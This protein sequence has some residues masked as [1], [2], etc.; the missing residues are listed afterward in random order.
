MNTTQTETRQ[1]LFQDT[2]ARWQGR[3]SVWLMN[4]KVKGW[5]SSGIR[6]N[7]LI[8]MAHDWDF[9]IGGHGTDEH[10]EYIEIK[11]VRP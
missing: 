10:G 4:T 11:A 6:Y 8:E 2:V 9:V 7:S 5:A 1:R 3:S